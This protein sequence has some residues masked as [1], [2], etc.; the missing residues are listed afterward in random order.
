M[1]KSSLCVTTCSDIV[2]L[3]DWQAKSFTGRDSHL[4][5]RF[6]LRSCA[7]RTCCRHSSSRFGFRAQPQYF[8]NRECT[9]HGRMSH[10]R[11]ISR[12][13]PDHGPLGMRT[14]GASRLSNRSAKASAT[15]STVRSDFPSGSNVVPL[16]A[17]R[18]VTSPT[19]MPTGFKVMCRM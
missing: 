1:L 3:S 13:F 19:K 7:W 9:S 10:S 2:A 8:P 6:F 14:K 16:T 5:R 18:T 4:R 11:Q 12:C 17:V 15:A